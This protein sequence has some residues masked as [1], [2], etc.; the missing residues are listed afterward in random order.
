MMPVKK[1]K[2]SFEIDMNVLMAALANGHS[3]M[4]IDAFQNAVEETRVSHTASPLQITDRGGMRRLM[5]NALRDNGKM[6]V[7]DLRL[8]IIGAGYSSKSLNS[9]LHDMLT[10]KFVRR[11]GKATYAVT[12]KG[13]NYVW[14]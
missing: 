6:K 3:A 5:A 11:A 10:K 4:N 14:T 2:I 9:A 1:L 8:L 7:G 13:L 12:K